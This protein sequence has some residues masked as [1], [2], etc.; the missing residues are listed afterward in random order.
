MFIYSIF[1]KASR[2]AID[3]ATDDLIGKKITDKIAKTASRKS[4]NLVM[5]TQTEE[6]NNTVEMPKQRYMPPKKDNKLLINLH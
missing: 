2:T 6:F 4:R 1:K 5:L 3:E